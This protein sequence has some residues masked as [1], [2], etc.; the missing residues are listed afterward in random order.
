VTTLDG[1][2]LDD[3]ER[4]LHELESE[5]AELRA[6]LAAG[7]AEATVEALGES[8]VTAWALRGTDRDD[9]GES[10]DEA[11]RLFE[12]GHIEAAA[13][14]LRN[15]RSQAIEDT[16]DPAILEIDD[17]VS[18]MRALIHGTDLT[19]FDQALPA[20]AGGAEPAAEVPERDL[21]AWAQEWID[22]GDFRGLLN[23]LEYTRRQALKNDDIAVLPD[24]LHVTELVAWESTGVEGRAA[25]LAEALRQNIR[26]LERKL[27]VR[28]DLAAGLPPRVEAP[29]EALLDVRPSGPE[30]EQP[31][32]TVGPVWGPPSFSFPDLSAADLFG[33]KA[34]AISGGIVTL[35]GIV[36]FFVL[37]VNRGWVGPEGRIGLGAFAALLVYGGG[38]ELRR[39]FG[40]TDA[41]LA[42]VAAGIAGGVQRA[43]GRSAALSLRRPCCSSG[44]RSRDRRHRPGHGA[45]LEL[46]D[47][48]RA[49]AARG[50]ARA[51]RNRGPGRDLRTRHGLRRLH[52]GGDRDGGDPR[53]LG[54]APR[55]GRARL[56]AA[57]TS[58][59]RAGAVQGRIT[60]ACFVT[61]AAIFSGITV[62]TGIAH[63]F[64]AQRR[65]LGPL[66]T[67]F[68]FA[69][70]A[71]A[72]GCAL[73]LYGS[74]ESRGFA[75]LA[76]AITFGL[77]ATALFPRRRERDLSVLVGAIGL[78]VGGIAFGEL[79]SGSPLAFAWAGEAAVLA[80]LARRV[81]EIRYQ[82]FALVYLAAAVIHVL[83]TDAP[84]T[85]LFKPLETSAGGALA[86]VATG[87]AAAVF[88]YY[89]A[90]RRLSFESHGGLF[91][92]LAPV[93][94]ELAARQRLLREAAYWL[95]GLAAVYAVSFGVLA[96][97][98]GFGWRHAAMYAVWSAIGLGL[99]AIGF[100]RQV[101][102]FRGGGLVGLGAT[103]VAAI[104]NG[105]RALSADPR[106]A[107]CLVGGVVLLAAALVELFF[108]LAPRW[109]QLV[110]D[111]R[112]SRLVTCWLGVV[113]SLAA[114]SVGVL[115][116][117]PSYGWGHFAM[118]A[119]WS[120][121]GLGVVI[122]A[123][124][125]QAGQIRAGGL[126]GLGVTLVVAFANGEK[127]IA[128]P[129][130]AG[131]TGS[132]P[133][134]D[135]GDAVT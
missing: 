3:F 117:V 51:A 104:A 27:G 98:P 86:V 63:Q 40:E 68:L 39:R 87:L 55:A 76:V 9:I 48:R 124:R 121:L 135:D 85:H 97:I 112:V 28:V 122:A 36:F 64:R 78:I 129:T 100:I 32:A 1:P 43:A 14:A 113:G 119:L 8:D 75:L 95:S 123:L 18:Q 103:V 114:L 31:A 19:D 82:L 30:V 79:M 128:R 88:G 44:C 73:R 15:L 7:G 2:R 74:P 108:V 81:K 80:W 13:D 34:L 94:E 22:R 69:G 106:A 37:A 23:A 29:V 25:R 107:A 12:E 67:S 6:G 118:Y 131:R 77:V 52:G 54:H 84:P 65:D 70:A 93:Y 71:L 127:S 102:K 24:L 60:G 45:P 116:A 26:F 110:Q 133:A 90:P 91:G 132:G 11:Q 130:L 96:A 17:M 58:A 92:L 56:A 62:G 99:F 109:E 120:A 83:A 101:G 105:E 57:G 53:A 41:S 42:A 5:L 21:P 126:V 125:R 35:L 4:R 89:A 50:Y 59:R 66:P 72:V 38:L 134:L 115:A 47:D 61:I 46:A 20:E 33:A 49:R 10:L 16:D 111:E